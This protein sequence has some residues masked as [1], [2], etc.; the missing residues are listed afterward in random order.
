MPY[1]STQERERVDHIVAN[2]IEWLG[3]PGTQQDRAWFWRVDSQYVE[4]Q[5]RHMTGNPVYKNGVP[6]MTWRPKKFYSFYFRHQTDAT[7][8]TLKWL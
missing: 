5:A 6:I 7:M 4:E 8:F 3:P 2:V 1:A